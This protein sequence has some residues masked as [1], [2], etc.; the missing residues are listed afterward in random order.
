M[1]VMRF[2]L[3]SVHGAPK[4]LPGAALWSSRRSL[5]GTEAHALI[6]TPRWLTGCVILSKGRHHQ[7]GW[8]YHETH[9]VVDQALSNATPAMPLC[10][11][12]P[13]NHIDWRLDRK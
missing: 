2:A 7:L 3:H 1:M 6:E 9:G 10:D 12:Q 4:E 8:G 13:P 5:C 11:G